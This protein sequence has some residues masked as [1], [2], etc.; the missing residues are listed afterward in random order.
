MTNQINYIIE[1]S[2]FDAARPFMVIIASTKYLNRVKGR[3]ATRK[4]AMARIRQLSAQ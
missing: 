1:M 2:K 3:Y 4:E